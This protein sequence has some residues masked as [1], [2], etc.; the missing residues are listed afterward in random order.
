[1]I[2]KKFQDDPWTVWWGGKQRRVGVLDLEARIPAG[3]T[4]NSDTGTSPYETAPNSAPRG[5]SEQREERFQ[6]FCFVSILTCS[7][8]IVFC[9]H[10]LMRALKLLT[11]GV[12]AVLLIWFCL[13]EEDAGIN[14]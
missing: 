13:L 9:V 14:H 5:I 3:W 4:G 7:A 8:L 11:I 6:F 12:W 1:M 2:L 10:T